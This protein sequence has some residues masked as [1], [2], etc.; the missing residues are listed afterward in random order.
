MTVVMTTVASTLVNR[1]LFNCRLYY[2]IVS[3]DICSLRLFL[4]ARELFRE[5]SEVT[6]LSRLKIDR[7]ISITLV[8][9]V[10][11]VSYARGAQDV[12]VLRACQTKLEMY[13]GKP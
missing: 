5:R 2:F 11:C 8:A 7:V 10:G 12:H 3:S 1:K 6:S 9:A 13:R 4:R